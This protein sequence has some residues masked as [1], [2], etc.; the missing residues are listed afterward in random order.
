MQENIFCNSC[1]LDG[2][3]PKVVVSRGNCEARIMMI[4]EAPGSKEDTLG[5]PFVG[6]SGKLLDKLLEKSG[7]DPYKDIYICNVIKCR[8]PRNRR[9][10]KK[11]IKLNMPW[12][13]QQIKLIDPLVIIL[14]GTTAVEAVLGIKDRISTLRGTWQNW[15]GR[16]IM[17]V[18]HPSYLLRNPS[19]EEG[20]PISLTSSDLLKVKDEISKIDFCPEFSSISESRSSQL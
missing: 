2:L 13:N 1:E 18:F 14:V 20:R 11:E 3:Q 15:K 16:L 19:K 9:P 17:P 5:K 6:R 8:P 12:L 10:T 4:G 7:I